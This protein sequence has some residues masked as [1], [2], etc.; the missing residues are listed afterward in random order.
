ML[1]K[2][3]EIQRK[4][5]RWSTRKRIFLWT[6]W[7]VC[8]LISIAALV[9]P[10]STRQAS[11]RAQVGDVVSQDIVAPR[12]LN[13]QSAVFTERDRR[14]A[15]DAVAPVYG[16][17]DATVARQQLEHLRSAVDFIDSVRADTY[18]T[19]EQKIG[20]LTALQNVSLG[21]ESAQAILLLND[22]AWQ[23]VRQEAIVVLEQIMR[24]SIRQSRLDE[25][26]RSVPALVS[27]SLPQDQATLVS[28][29]VAAFVAPNSFYS[30]TLTQAARQEASAAV[31]PAVRTFVTN[32]IIVSRGQVLNEADLEA[33]QQFGLVQPETGWQNYVGAVAVAVVTFSLAALFLRFRSELLDRVRELTL[34]STLFVAFLLVARFV[35]VDRT[36]MPYLF[37]VAGFGL[38]TA[39]LYSSRAAM[40]FSL[41]LSVLAA[42][43]LPNAFDL[44]LYYFIGSLFGI[45]FLK[46]AQRVMTY[47]WAGAAVMVAGAAV[48]I[49]YRLPLAS[50]DIVGLLTLVG[51]AGLNGFFSA[52]LT[53]VLQLFLAQW[54]GLTTTVQLME[55]A[56]PDHPLLQF[57]MRHAPGT[58][59][60]S[61]LIANLAEQAAEAIGAD[62]LLTRIGSLYHD[63]GKAR[64]PHFFI[65]NQVTGATNPHEDLTPVESAQRII[66]HVPDGVELAH[67]HRLP[68]RIV[69]FIKEHHGTLVT[70][71]QYARALDAVG[72]DESKVNPRDFRYDGP[73]PQSRETALVMLADGCEARTRAERPKTQEEL[74]ALVR[75]VIDGRLN[76]GQLDDTTLTMRDLA[77]VA[78]TFITG[79]RGVYHPR[80]VYPDLDEKT[81]N[82]LDAQPAIKSLPP[83][84]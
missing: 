42:Y 18:A 83:K 71:Y 39:T 3:I 84:H 58:Y 29:I 78:D 35:I 12:T 70:R 36:V 73:R 38:L 82:A 54:L 21:R 75:S 5:P 67:K 34:V 7:A 19:L 66:R 49:A 13:Y 32:E 74:S 43:N 6:L 25:A 77:I 40:V 56:R 76:N 53:I 14:E 22:N 57:L 80:L 61:L 31:S 26:R 28:E 4:E 46:R 37:P 16:A 2:P 15:A 69:D 20:D 27:L 24:S 50:T 30:E 63:A 33:L 60:H 55:L 45:L 41:V 51:A 72:G 10:F 17:P 64:Q 9:M 65:E 47:F 11:L 8:L 1:K 44:T 59:Q 62:A 48:L 23:N 79:L 81:L 52:S 68:Q